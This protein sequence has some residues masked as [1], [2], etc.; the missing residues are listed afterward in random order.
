MKGHNV[1]FSVS[2]ETWMTEIKQQVRGQQPFLGV[3]NNLPHRSQRSDGLQN[4]GH[5]ILLAICKSICRPLTANK[6]CNWGERP[7]TVF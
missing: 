3:G 7:N 1:S 5:F 2:M 6:P 4:G